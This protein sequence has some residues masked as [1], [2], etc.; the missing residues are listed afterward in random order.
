MGSQVDLNPTISQASSCFKSLGGDKWEKVTPE[1]PAHS[2]FTGPSLF[3]TSV[4]I[5]TA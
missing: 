4:P 3:K 2:Q 5:I 1:S